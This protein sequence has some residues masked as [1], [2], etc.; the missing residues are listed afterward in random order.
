MG[1]GFDLYQNG[2][3]LGSVAINGT[4]GW[5]SWTTVTY[6]FVLSEG[7]SDIEIRFTSPGLN[8]NYFVVRK[9]D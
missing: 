7:N 3:L 9:V 2:N 6:D 4:G 5:Q 1:G 8:I